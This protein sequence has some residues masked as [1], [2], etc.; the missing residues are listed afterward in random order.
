MTL[1]SAGHVLDNCAYDRLSVGKL[2][3]Y[4]CLLDGHERSK[5]GLHRLL[6]ISR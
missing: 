2:F 6:R 1:S 4:L 5:R 3:A